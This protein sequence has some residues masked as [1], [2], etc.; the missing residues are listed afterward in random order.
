MPEKALFTYV[1][2]AREGIVY[3]RS[4][5]KLLASSDLLARFVVQTNE[6]MK[7]DE[8]KMVSGRYRTAVSAIGVLVVLFP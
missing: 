2:N 8:G 3:S 1:S 4:S 5:S 7:M 6:L